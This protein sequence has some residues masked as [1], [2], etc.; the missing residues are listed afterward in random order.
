MDS[1][2][3]SNLT[4][5]LPMD[6]LVYRKDAFRIEAQRRVEAEDPYFRDLSRRWSEALRD[7][8]GAIPNPPWLAAAAAGR[9]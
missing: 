5:G 2:L 3:R 1:T 4:V 9:P 6:L 7:A 8:Y